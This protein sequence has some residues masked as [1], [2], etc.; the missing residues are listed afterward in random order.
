[1][2]GERQIVEHFLIGFF[3]VVGHGVEECL[4]VADHIIIDKV[5]LHPLLLYFRG[6]DV[7]LIA[8]G[9]ASG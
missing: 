2:E 4:F 5:I 6:L 8:K 7:S 1:M 3:V 9:F